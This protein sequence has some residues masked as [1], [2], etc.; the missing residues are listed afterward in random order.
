MDGWMDGWNNT[1]R[2]SSLF[3][4]PEELDQTDLIDDRATYSRVDRS[5]IGKRT[6]DRSTSLQS[7]VGWDVIAQMGDRN[8]DDEHG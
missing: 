3:R 1:P 8:E 2:I 4:C 6:N 7:H 5:P